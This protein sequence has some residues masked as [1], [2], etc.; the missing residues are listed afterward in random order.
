MIGLNYESCC[1]GLKILAGQTGDESD[2]FAETDESIY[3][4]FTLKGLSAAGQDI[5]AQL[6]ES[7]PGYRAAF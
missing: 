3:V 4:E 7:I 2:D 5:D 1:W 6:Q